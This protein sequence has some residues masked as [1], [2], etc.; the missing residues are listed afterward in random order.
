MSQIGFSSAY[1]FLAVDLVTLNRKISCA[2]KGEVVNIYF[3]M[4]SGSMSSKEIPL[5]TELQLDKFSAITAEQLSWEKT[6]VKATLMNRSA[7]NN[8]T[9]HIPL[10]KFVVMTNDDFYAILVD[11][12]DIG[13]VKIGSDAEGIT[14]TIF[15]EN[16]THTKVPALRDILW[17]HHGDNVRKSMLL[18]MS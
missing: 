15:S 18:Y 2:G 16:I 17:D 14:Y 9:L 3:R 1:D 12:P 11:H 5:F 10:C 7:Y 6:M 4:N 8:N 13:I